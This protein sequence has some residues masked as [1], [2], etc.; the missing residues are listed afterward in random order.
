MQLSIIQKFKNASIWEK[1]AEENLYPMLKEMMYPTEWANKFQRNRSLE[2]VSYFL[3][4]VLF[5]YFYD[6]TFY[7]FAVLISVYTYRSKYKKVTNVYQA[8]KFNRHLQFTKFIRLLIPYLK[9]S[10]GSISLY[11][12]FNRM[13]IRMEEEADR[14]SLYL[15]M[16]EMGNRPNQIEPFIDYAERSSGTDKSVLFMST[17]FDFQQNPFNAD[18]IDGLGRDS[19]EELLKSIDEIIHLKLKK[20]QNIP[21]KI[22][23]TAFF[24]FVG[25][26]ISFA[27]DL[28]INIF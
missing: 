18:V 6:P 25:F 15:L 28:V 14:N 8:W 16:S 10:K 27:W 19:S 20:F 4:L 21:M 7:I 26:F 9:K 2:A 12:I 11:T 17:I 13:L 3:V 5:G 24:L 22:V 1:I 23:M